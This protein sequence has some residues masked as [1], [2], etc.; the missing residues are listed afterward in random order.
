MWP[1]KKDRGLPGGKREVDGQISFTLTDEEDAAIRRFFSIMKGTGGEGELYIHPEAHRAMTA[2][3]LIGYAQDQVCRAENPAQNPEGFVQ[4]A[5]ASA[6]KA[7][8]LHPLP[9]YMFD[10]GCLFRMLDDEASARDSFQTFLRANQTFKPTESDRIALS[11]R[12]IDA[13]VLEARR[14]LGM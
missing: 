10:M 8:S 5:L 1:F 3:A 12:D 2:W 14:S 9:I 7:Y 6:M 4:K 13:A 11:N